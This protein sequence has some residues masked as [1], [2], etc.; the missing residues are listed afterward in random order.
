MPLTIQIAIFDGFDEIDVFGP[1]EILS[2]AGFCVN[3]ASLAGSGMVTSM[4][5]ISVAV[6][7][8][9]APCDGVIVPGGG[10]LNRAASGAWA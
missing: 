5:G 7:H 4:R 6:G 9:L 2:S 10:W 8:R 1:F 3:L